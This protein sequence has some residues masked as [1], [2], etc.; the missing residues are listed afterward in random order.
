[1]SGAKPSGAGNFPVTHWSVVLT[2]GKPDST[3]AQVALSQLCQT[4]WFPLYAHARRRGYNPHD[5]EDLTQEFFAQLLEREAF[6]AADPFRGRFR[7]FLLASMNN[8]LTTEWKKARAQKRDAAQEILSLD[9]SAAEGRYDLEPADNFTPD[10]AFDKQWALA[11]LDTVLKELEADYLATGKKDLF[12]ALRQTLAGSR[13]AQAYG[14]LAKSLAMSEGAVK[15][16]VH[17]LRGRYRDLIRQQIANTVATPEEVA[18][19]MR[20]LFAALAGG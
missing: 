5:A 6:A 7:S 14:E 1:M 9:F 18:A 19:E 16:A 13:E 10:K 2:A 15:V 17:R 8:F 4:Y 20:H 3:R 11:L 12:S